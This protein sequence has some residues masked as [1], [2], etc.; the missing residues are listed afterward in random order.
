MTENVEIKIKKS[1]KL[2][3]LKALIKEFSR[4]KWYDWRKVDEFHN[5]YNIKDIKCRYITK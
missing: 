3:F 1:F 4:I 2:Y 5:K